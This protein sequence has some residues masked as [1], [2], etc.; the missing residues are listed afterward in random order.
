MHNC[1]PEG[2]SLYYAMIGHSIERA[3]RGIYIVEADDKEDACEQLADVFHH[4]YIKVPGD[5]IKKTNEPR[6]EVR[7]LY[8]NITIQDVIAHLTHGVRS[9]QIPQYYTIHIGDLVVP[10]GE[11]YRI[12]P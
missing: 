9:I 8:E 1:G 4:K 2:M 5:M 7:V 12:N 10:K 6:G 11:P 3:T